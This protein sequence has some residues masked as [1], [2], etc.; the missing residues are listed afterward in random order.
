MA[1]EMD[2]RVNLPVDPKLVDRVAS[3]PRLAAEQGPDWL[4]EYG[5]PGNY[6]ALSKVSGS[7]RDVWFKINA[8]LHFPD[9]VMVATGLS[10]KD[11]NAAVKRLARK[12]LVNIESDDPAF[13]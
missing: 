10:Q 4:S 3:S 9:Q 7:D 6:V 8:G 13:A 5:G 1:R 2:P 12:H 11:L